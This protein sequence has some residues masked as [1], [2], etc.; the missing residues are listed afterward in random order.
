MEP[1][2]GGGGTGAASMVRAYA[3]A[4]SF[5]YPGLSG[6][7]TT[8]VDHGADMEAYNHLLEAIAAKFG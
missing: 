4:S 1:T 2:F 3:A 5:S 8:Q 6:I 7:G